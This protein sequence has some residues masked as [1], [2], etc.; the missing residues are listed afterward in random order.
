VFIFFLRD[1]WVYFVP[2]MVNLM[3][4]PNVSSDSGITKTGVQKVPNFYHYVADDDSVD[5]DMKFQVFLLVK[6]NLQPVCH[7]SVTLD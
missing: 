5:K 2:A 6:Q 7:R 3:M 1:H 4:N